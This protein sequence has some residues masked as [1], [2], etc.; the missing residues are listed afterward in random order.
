MYVSVC[1]FLGMIMIKDVRNTESLE[2]CA[3]KEKI[4]LRRTNHI[5]CKGEV[6]EGVPYSTP[7]WWSGVNYRNTMHKKLNPFIPRWYLL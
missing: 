6:F 1:L 3:V 2:M 5:Y 4:L 7:F